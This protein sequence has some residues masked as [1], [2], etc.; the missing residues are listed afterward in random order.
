[1]KRVL[2][3]AVLA[4][5]IPAT[6]A[7]QALTSLSSLRVRY[8]TQ[9][10]TVDP[11]G[12]LKAQIDD[13]DRAIAEATRTGRTGEL[14]GLF[15]KGTALLEGREWSD[16][17]DFAASLVIRSDRVVV[18][19]TLPWTS[20]WSRSTHRRSSSSSRLAR[21]RCSASVTEEQR[22]AAGRNC[23]GGVPGAS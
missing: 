9:K 17:A 18:D 15:A 19:S 16:A 20:G 1:M 4:F 13:V 10:A 14:R 23:A 7:S 11:Q 22:Q 6:A 5:V 2:I 3:L 8:N 21:T 12:E